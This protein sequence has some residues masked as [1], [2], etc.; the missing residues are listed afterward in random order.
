M[1][2]LCCPQVKSG[3]PSLLPSPHLGGEGWDEIIRGN[4]A[5]QAGSVC[6]GVPVPLLEVLWLC[7]VLLLKVPLPRECVAAQIAFHENA[8]AK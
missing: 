5:C 7:L 6:S 1:L 2:G 8:I 4:P 3:V